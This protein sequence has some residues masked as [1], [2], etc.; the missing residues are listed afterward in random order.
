MD[1]DKIL[2]SSLQS[3]KTR[4]ERAALRCALGDAAALCDAIN[5]DIRAEH[6]TKREAISK[7]GLELSEVA[8]KCG[9]A[10]WAMREKIDVPQ[11]SKSPYGPQAT[12]S[13]I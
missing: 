6:K 5:R 9:D 3:Y 2:A 13:E 11:N 12:R 4:E 10:I 7:R 1:A 8:R